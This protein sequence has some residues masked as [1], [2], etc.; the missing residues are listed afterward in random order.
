MAEAQRRAEVAW[1]GNLQNGSGT[2]DL[3]SSGVLERS[4][5][6]FATRAED[7]DG[8]TSPEELIAAAHAS[9]YAM[10]F[11]N[12]LGEGG[13]DPEKLD[14]SATCTLDL[15][16]LKISTVELNVRGRVPGMDQGQFEEAAQEAEQLCPVSNA[17]RGNVEI[18]LNASLES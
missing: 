2:F 12:V 10:A 11:S 5:V 4:A 15:D 8:Q 14:V 1:E 7:P 17:L 9:C 13:N 18:E 3:A 16:N 6:S